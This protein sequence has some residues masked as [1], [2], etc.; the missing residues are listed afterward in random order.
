MK[1]A[2]NVRGLRSAGGEIAVDRRGTMCRKERGVRVEMKEEEVSPYFQ[3][4]G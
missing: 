2:R 1:E 4:N 3:T